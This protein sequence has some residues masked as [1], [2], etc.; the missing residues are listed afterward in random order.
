[1]IPFKPNTKTGKVIQLYFETKS[2][3]MKKLNITRPTIDKICR[4][5]E[6]FYKYVPKIAKS[7]KVPIE[8]VLLSHK[9][10]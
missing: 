9:K 8:E 4:C 3:A 5:E 6:A 10:I 7:C 2:E 1:M